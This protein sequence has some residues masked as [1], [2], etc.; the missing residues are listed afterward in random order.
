MQLSHAL[1]G[2]GEEAVRGPQAQPET[3][4]VSRVEAATGRSVD[5]SD[6]GAAEL[7]YAARGLQT[8]VAQ[9]LSRVD[10]VPDPALQRLAASVR[11]RSDLVTS[12]RR[13]LRDEPAY[14]QRPR[15]V[16]DLTET[17]ADAL[18]SLRDG[19]SE[20]D[21]IMTSLPVAPV[22]V[23]GH[24]PSLDRAVSRTSAILA[25]A[26]RGLAGHSPVETT[27]AVALT[28]AGARLDLTVPGVEIS[29]AALTEVVEAFLAATSRP[30][31]ATGVNVQV[32]AGR[33]CVVTDPVTATTS[34][35]ETTVSALWEL[36]GSLDDVA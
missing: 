32:V 21:T 4:Q 26:G 17:I 13:L 20:A 28:R 30:R 24:A 9:L 6:A 10:A 29:A 7:S 19:S 8:E 36:E 12:T 23:M 33:V 27:V 2:P 16:F 35:D 34:A 3:E 18:H 22:R 5:S 11:R 14:G 15:A 31:A 1:P 25:G